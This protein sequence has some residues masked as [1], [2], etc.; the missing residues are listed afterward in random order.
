MKNRLRVVY[1]LLCLSVGGCATAP[2]VKVRVLDAA[3]RAPVSDVAIEDLTL[4]YTGVKSLEVADS[5]L[6]KTGADG[7]YVIKRVNLYSRS[8]TISFAKPGYER[9]DFVLW[10]YEGQPFG[11]VV[12]ARNEDV[13][14]PF[15]LTDSTVVEIS[16]R[17]K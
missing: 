9:M 5:R 1:L 2:D 15:R 13:I 17:R 10:K 6:G 11:K 8:H 12:N 3:S 16:M 7:L 14:P 4:N